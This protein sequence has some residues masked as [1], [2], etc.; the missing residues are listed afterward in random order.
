MAGGACIVLSMWPEQATISAPARGGPA[1]IRPDHE[2]ELAG[3]DGGGRRR[4]DEDGD[5]ERG[6]RRGRLWRPHLQT[7]EQLVVELDD[8][9]A[10]AERAQREIAQRLAAGGGSR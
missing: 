3:V 6:R 9:L 10:V 7:A 4:E 2:R 8:E 5:V 1:E